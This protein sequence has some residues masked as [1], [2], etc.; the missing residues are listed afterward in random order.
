MSFARRIVFDTGV[1]VS[2]A[3][4]PESVPALALE[5]ALL[6]FEVCASDAT[7]AELEV[8]LLR[9]KFDRYADAATRRVFVEGFRRHAR[10]VVVERQVADCADPADD[11]FLALADAAGAELIVA[12]DPHL[13]DMHPWRGIPIMPPSAFLVA[14]R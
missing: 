13:T 6:H 8:V 11:K 2:A 7:L 14:I 5:K 4:L 3:I 10:R 12:S 1:L 9:P